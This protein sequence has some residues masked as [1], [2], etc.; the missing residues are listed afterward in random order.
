MKI[1]YNG[2]LTGLALQLAVGPVFFY[3]V[4]LTLQKTTFYLFSDFL[5]D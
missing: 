4:N 3:I 2:L 5:R 1:F